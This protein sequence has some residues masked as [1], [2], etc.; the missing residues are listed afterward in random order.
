[1]IVFKCD[2]SAFY[3]KK[4]CTSEYESKNS[5]ELPYKW[6]VIDFTLYQNETN[7]RRLIR[8]GGLKHFC[9]TACFLSY[10]Y[11]LGHENLIRTKKIYPIY[12]HSKLYDF[13]I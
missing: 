9:C 3:N 2:G 7:N 12:E 1:M 8:G 10:F 13:S 5:N 11:C 6:I 4:K